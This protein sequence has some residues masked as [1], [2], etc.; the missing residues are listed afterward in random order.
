MSVT[1]NS[2]IQIDLVLDAA[3]RAFDRRLIPV[4]LCATVYRDVE[5]QGTDKVSVPYYPLVAA[6]TT[7]NFTQGTGYE[8]A[9]GT[10]SSKQVTVNKRKYQPLE[11]TSAEVARQPML[12]EEKLG[13]MMGERLAEDVLNDIFSVITAANFGAAAVA[14]HSNAFDSDDVADLRTICNQAHWPKGPS[15]RGL[16][17][18]SAYDGNLVKDLKNYSASGS[19]QIWRNGEL[20]EVLGFRY[21][22]SPIVPANGEGLVGFAINPSAILVAFSPIRPQEAVLRVTNDYRRFTNK[23][24]LTLE[25]REMGNAYQDTSLRVIEANYGYVLGET[26]A[27]KRITA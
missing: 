25:Y 5:L 3:M 17:L 27:C 11:L 22:E 2:Q 18:D 6:G 16:V 10:I 14:G 13:M 21:A 15:F 23:Q 8:A 24:G 12:N 1:I 4:D 19:D 20:Q 26:A 9:N 7:K